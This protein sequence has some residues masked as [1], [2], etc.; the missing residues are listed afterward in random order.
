MTTEKPEGAAALRE[1]LL[2]SKATDFGFAPTPEL[3]HVWAAMMEMQFSKATAS[4]VA[5]RDGATS[6]YFSTGGGVIGGEAHQPVRE[7]NRKFLS[8]IERFLGAKAFVP[9]ISALAVVKDAVTFNV[10][11]YDGL[12]AAR[13]TEARMQ[14]RKSP[15][16]PL[17]LL[18]QDVI[19]QLR[20]T[21]EKK[22]GA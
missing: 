5:V 17:Y 18:G 13:D 20:L 16:W 22:S 15:L 11:T 6:L 12:V 4:L 7:A 10:L 8:A 19:T 21:A 1:M 9:Q 3:P 14:S 2:R